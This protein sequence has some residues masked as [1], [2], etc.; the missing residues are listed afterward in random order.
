MELPWPA[1][2]RAEILCFSV[3]GF[4]SACGVN[5]YRRTSTTPKAEPMIRHG[6]QRQ[7]VRLRTARFGLVGTKGQ[8]QRLTA[9]QAISHGH[10]TCVEPLAF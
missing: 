5:L 8:A 10:S 1:S 4:G 3:S 2:L 7:V 9:G 6:E